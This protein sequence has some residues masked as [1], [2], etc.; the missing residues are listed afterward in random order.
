MG[1]DIENTTTDEDEHS[2]I[3]VGPSSGTYPAV[4]RQDAAQSENPGC[5]ANLLAWALL[6]GVIAGIAWGINS[7]FTDDSD[8]SDAQRAEPLSQRS[9]RHG[10]D[11]EGGANSTAN[12][13]HATPVAQ[14]SAVE[15]GG[16]REP[17]PQ[18]T[19]LQSPRD[20]VAVAMIDSFTLHWSPVEHA[21][22]YEFRLS[23]PTLSCDLLLGSRPGIECMQLVPD[24]TYTVTIRATSSSAP[25]SSWISEQVKTLPLP[26]PALPSNVTIE[27]NE[28]YDDIDMQAVIDAVAEVADWYRSEYDLIA[29]IPSFIRFEPQCRP[30][31]HLDVL[32]YSMKGVDEDGERA[33]HVCIRLDE[34]ADSILAT[35]SFKWLVAHEYFHVLQANAGWAFDEGNSLSSASRE[36]GRQLIEGSA[37]WFGQ[38]YAW[39]ELQGEG[40]LESL[41]SLLAGDSERR[42]YYDEGARAFEALIGWKGL[43]RA[44]QF[45][46]SDE[47]RCADA[48]LAEFDVAP[49]K[50]ESDWREL[51]SR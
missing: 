31:R 14:D 28:R 50:Y 10:Q 48:F 8:Q 2:K 21:D 45:W 23:G 22:D 18:A 41:A 11:A 37:E 3:N 12:T 35:E 25:P 38:M 7:C 42:Y 46:E 16:Q 24:T 49:G 44:A 39:G 29:R 17:A 32:G 20:F 6:L 51:T 19:A 47:A 27:L 15:A 36:C 34:D 40:L 43:Q 30:T 26:A 9:A 4:P 1:S 5:L 33:V 13:A